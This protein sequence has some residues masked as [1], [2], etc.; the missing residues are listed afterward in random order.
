[1]GYLV[2]SRRVGER[3]MIKSE[4]DEI[5]ILISDISQDKVDVAVSAPKNYDIKRRV[6][7]LEET[8]D[9]VTIR[10]LSRSRHKRN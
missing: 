9:G 7:P 1:M 6:T 8:P 5:E 10:N 3:I 2:I 4:T